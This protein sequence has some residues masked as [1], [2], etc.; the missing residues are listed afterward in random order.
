MVRLLLKHGA[1]PHKMTNGQRQKALSMSATE[2]IAKMLKRAEAAT[3]SKKVEDEIEEEDGEEDEEEKSILF[4]INS[5]T[6]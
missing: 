5:K 1:D 6:M 3:K 2:S 4:R